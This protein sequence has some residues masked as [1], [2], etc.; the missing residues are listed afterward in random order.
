[1][2]CNKLQNSI[3]NLGKKLSSVIITGDTSGTRVLLKHYYAL[4]ALF[5]VIYV[6]MCVCVY[7]GSIVKDRCVGLE[8]DIIP[9]GLH[10]EG[11]L[12]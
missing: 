12:V 2:L 5:P 4:L 11:R 1:M 6:Y 3:P 10:Q 7:N 9:L 8:G